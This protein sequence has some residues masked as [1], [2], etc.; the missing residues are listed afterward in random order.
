MRFLL[1]FAFSIR[2]LL[3]GQRCGHF[4]VI[5]VHNKINKSRNGRNN[6]MEMRKKPSKPPNNGKKASKP[7]NFSRTIEVRSSNR[8]KWNTP[9][10]KQMMQMRT[11]YDPYNARDS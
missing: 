8:D 4:I 5:I 2:T 9:K 1:F 10:P 11:D 6:G 3:L 7:P